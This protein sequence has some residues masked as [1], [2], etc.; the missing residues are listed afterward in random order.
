M[1]AHVL[2]ALGQARKRLIEKEQQTIV[3][4]LFFQNNQPGGRLDFYEKDLMAAFAKSQDLVKNVRFIQFPRASQSI[5]EA[6]L[7]VYGLVESDPDAWENLADFYIWGS[8]EEIE[9]SGVPFERV[10]VK[11]AITIWDGHSEP[12]TFTKTATVAGLSKLS[13]QI[14]RTVTART[15]AYSR[16]PRGDDIRAQVA[17]SLLARASDIQK[18]I[19]QTEHDNYPNIST[20]WWKRR[21]YTIQ[22]LSIASFFDPS[23]EKI[24]TALL[25][26]TTRD[27]IYYLNKCREGLFWRRWRRSNAWK[28]HCQQFGFNYKHK[29][30]VVL[31]GKRGGLGDNRLDYDY[32]TSVLA[33]VGSVMDVINACRNPKKYKSLPSGIPKDVPPEVLESWRR[34]LAVDF[35][36]R[37]YNVTESFPD[38]IK[39][40]SHNYLYAA[41]LNLN[42]S[43][44]RIQLI[45]A[46]WPAAIQDAWFKSNKKFFVNQLQET[47][48]QTKNSNR[49]NELIAMIA[50]KTP[51]R[52][53]PRVSRPRNN[54]KSPR[55]KI[56]TL[57]PLIKPKMQAISF[58]KHFHVQEVT[59]IANIGD[60]LWVGVRGQKKS[61]IRQGTAIF[62]Y[63]T[64][65][66]TIK[67]RTKN[68]GSHSQATSMLPKDG[69]LWITF[70]TDGVWSV[71]PKSLKVRK[72][73]TRDGLTSHEMSCS[74]AVKNKLYFAGGPEQI[75][76]LCS[77]DLVS[78]KWTGHKLPQ[79]TEQTQNNKR[80]SLCHLTEMAANE[81]WLVA[82]SHW[83]GASTRIMVFDTR[84]RKWTEVAKKLLRQHPEF[85]HFSN[86]RSL[87]VT[88]FAMDRE[89]V[90]IGSTKGLLLL[91]P[92]TKNF[93]YFHRLDFEVTSILS[94]GEYLW[95]ALSDQDP[96]YRSNSQARTCILRFHKPTRKWCSQINMPYIG[97][98]NKMVLLDSTLWLGT[99][100]AKNTIVSVDLTN[101]RSQ[102]N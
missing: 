33:Y 35:G 19:I 57:A 18:L 72:Y 30:I 8:Y 44:L 59:S 2:S 32:S 36:A 53:P 28:K 75:A 61:S 76:A 73:T 63:D 41:L 91:N 22:I 39:T 26:E 20:T 4:P 27:D 62:T 10:K 79:V 80:F 69:L 67:N 64:K 25:V 21:Q 40:R 78:G 88:G 74:S 29:H 46:L 94:D 42:D 84:R 23:N 92:G 66:G 3:A 51:K 96:K 97:V 31:E 102:R 37:L 49:A 87:R 45:E 83:G 77:F 99:S 1:C 47:Y 60:T 89:G 98:V 95:V 93:D 34:E 16:R 86:G 6:E 50:E 11:A 52:L 56:E 65:R 81:K 5:E 101:I 48:S 15:K 14:I 7:V 54:E 68:F 13:N 100:G 90:W 85:S 17:Q 55:S 70:E 12:E 82:Y 24:R 58:E 9:S 43:K 71:D 38:K